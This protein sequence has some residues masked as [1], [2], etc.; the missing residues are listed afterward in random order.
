[1]KDGGPREVRVRVGEREERGRCE[2]AQVYGRGLL[3]PKSDAG[4]RGRN[5]S[6]VEITGGR[7]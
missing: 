4:Q 6:V 3:S 5:D 2:D 7:G 1:M